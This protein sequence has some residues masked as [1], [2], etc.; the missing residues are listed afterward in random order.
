MNGLDSFSD[1]SSTQVDEIYNP[2]PFYYEN[3]ENKQVFTVYSEKPENFQHR[4]TI[5]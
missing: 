3:R 4:S 1:A 2:W 5:K